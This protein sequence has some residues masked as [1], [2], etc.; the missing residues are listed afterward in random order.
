M[1]PR[2][3]LLG[4]SEP[5]RPTE[6]DGYSIERHATT[7]WIHAMR[8]TRGWMNG[9]QRCVCSRWCRGTPPWCWLV[10][11]V[12]S[13][14]RILAI[15]GLRDRW[16]SIARGSSGLIPC[17]TMIRTQVRCSSSTPWS[18]GW[19]PPPASRRWVGGCCSCLGEIERCWGKMGG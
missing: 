6:H 16:N 5:S 14:S 10:T 19:P 7:L 12:S 2:E 9:F 18:L 3:E 4:F 15:T 1:V 17:T 11:V 8:G 13:I